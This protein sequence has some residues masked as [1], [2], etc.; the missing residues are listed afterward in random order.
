MSSDRRSILI[1]ANQVSK[2]YRV[3]SKPS[4]RLLAL[5]L[6]LLV[7]AFPKSKRI[8]RWLKSTSVT[9]E[10]LKPTDL[11]LHAG[12]AIGIIGS[13]GAGKSTLLQIIT[14]SLTPSSGSV[15]R[16]GK[17]AALLELGSGFDPECSGVE[18]VKINASLLGLSDKDIK[19]KFKSILEYADIGDFVHQPVKTY[20][21]GM[22]MRLAFAVAAH[23]EADVIIIDEALGVGDA[24]FQM[25]CAKTIEGHLKRG[26]SLLF[27]SHNMNAVKQLCSSA[28]LLHQGEC[29]MKGEPNDVANIY[30]RIT[31]GD[32]TNEV[33]MHIARLA[34]K[35]DDGPLDSR[36]TDIDEVDPLDFPPN[37]SSAFQESEEEARAR[38]A[39]LCFYG[40]NR[41]QSLLEFATDKTKLSE[42]EFM[43]GGDLGEICE[44]SLV[45][46]DGQA[47]NVITT[48][49]IFELRFRVKAHEYI[50]AP[51]FAMTIKDVKGQEVYVCNTV[52]R[53]VEVQP[54][55]AGQSYLVKFRQRMNLMQGEYFVSL[56]FVAFGGEELLVIQRRYDVVRLQVLPQDKCHGIANLY[57]VISYQE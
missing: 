18:N 54:L 21:S 51:V 17:I 5:A 30:S 37:M 41:L 22:R 55:R 11:K 15:T 42:T 48:G 27:V 47:K 32:S 29:L 39:T 3:W 24:R 52:Y 50:D 6:E 19:L 1:E 8:S 25:K 13:N 10:A 53:G 7:V 56:G 28:V 2:S 38:L 4:K 40:E 57:S 46:W 9:V 12:E 49:E 43:Y 34:Y 31:A 33:K 16:N 44:I 20:S 14:G 36:L 23:V 26:S 35:K 45:G